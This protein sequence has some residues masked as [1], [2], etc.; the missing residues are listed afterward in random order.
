MDE[1]TELVDIELVSTESR[2]AR[3]GLGA[4]FVGCALVAALLG[5]AYMATS[6]GDSQVDIAAEQDDVIPGAEPSNDDASSTED[7]PMDAD[8][9]VAPDEPPVAV[10]DGDAEFAS[11]EAADSEYY[12]GN[13]DDVIFDGTRFISIGYSE[14]GQTIRTSLDGIDWDERAFPGLP[15]NSNVYRLAEHDGTVVAVVEQWQE[16]EEAGDRLAE[17]FGPSEGPTQFLAS[18]TD[19][20]TWTYTEI[21]PADQTDGIVYRSITGLALGDSGVVMFL[22]SHPEGE[23][24]LRLLF[25]AGV[26]DSSTIERYC[27]VSFADS[28]D[29]DV[30]LCSHEEDE[31][32]WIELEEAMNAAESDEER[33][34]IERNFDETFVEPI[35]EIVA[36]ITSGDPLHEQLSSIYN[37]E[38]DLPENIVISGPVSGPWAESS[39]PTAGYPSSV[40]ELDGTFVGVIQRWDESLT[41]DSVSTIVVRSTNG[42]DWVQAGLLP[43]GSSERLVAVGSNLVALG[44]GG[45]SGR[46]TTSISSDLGD[47]WSPGTLS[48]D[49]FGVY[50]QPTHGPAGIAV[51][52]RGSTTPL[53][54]YEV[55]QDIVLSKDGYTLTMNFS[56]EGSRAI[57]AGPDGVEI[58]SLNEEDMYGDAAEG[59]VRMGR[60]S[61]TQTFLDP[62][63]GVDLVAF[64]EEDFEEAYTEPEPEGSEY[65]EGM[66]ILFS[67]DGQTWDPVI[68]SRLDIDLRQGDVRVIA[69]GDDEIIVAVST[70]TEPPVE[71]FAFEQEQRDPTEAEEQ[72]LNEWFE[73]NG[74]GN[75]TEYLSIPVG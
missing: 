70:W 34:E 5:G 31:R 23:N 4:A 65:V 17:F 58:Y 20:E 10:H 64:G 56:N 1:Q 60:F 41:E 12:G 25:D 30:Q 47:S 43:S 45:E 6:D 42:A 74:G 24:E 46:L 32:M 48:T 9:P 18:S 66:E 7:L 51:V 59:I 11:E 54:E 26:L 39:L 67:A 52:L 61:G 49:L 71:L 15:E 69:V 21:P 28:G 33:A 27:G 22:Q 72:A 55:P 63:T 40:I 50:P 2:R 3:G 38:Q 68:D 57:L 36:T 75:N 29:I 16:L 35:P 62:D 73:S 44:G 13:S 37:G 8:L 14:S 53:R 19:L